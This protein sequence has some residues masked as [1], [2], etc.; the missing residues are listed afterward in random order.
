MTDDNIVFRHAQP[1]MPNTELKITGACTCSRSHSI[2]VNAQTKAFIWIIQAA[3][4][5]EF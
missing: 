5:V 4:C 3:K 1:H 2:D